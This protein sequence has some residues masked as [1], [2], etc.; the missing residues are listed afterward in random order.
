MFIGRVVNWELVGELFGGK[1]VASVSHKSIHERT[2]Q[3]THKNSTSVFF[4]N[5]VFI[6]LYK[7]IHMC[8]HLPTTTT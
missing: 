7:V 1:L 2:E 5:A 8:I 3:I 4:E 6:R